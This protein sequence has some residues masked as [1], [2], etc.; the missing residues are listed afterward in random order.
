MA[1]TFFYRGTQYASIV[2]HF[3]ILLCHLEICC[4][5]EG[6]V[7]AGEK[8]DGGGHLRHFAEAA[9]HVETTPHRLPY[10]SLAL[11]R[12]NSQII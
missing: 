8:G 1:L 9:A 6:G 11:S 5:D 12:L 3:L 10:G 4:I 2:L 7:G